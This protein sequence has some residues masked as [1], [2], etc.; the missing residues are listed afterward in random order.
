MVKIKVKPNAF[1]RLTELGPEV[2]GEINARLLNNETP[3]DISRWLHEDLDLMKDVKVQSVA[4]MIARYRVKALRKHVVEEALFNMKGR[5][6]S[7]LKTRL[8]ALDEI[9]ELVVLQRGRVDQCLMIEAGLQRLSPATREEMKLLKDLLVQLGH[10]QLEMGILPKASK[11]ITGMVVEDGKPKSFSWTEEQE[12]LSRLIEAH[13]S[14]F[15][16][17]TPA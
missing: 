8:S 4:K 11:T 5:S 6:T 3:A 17:A 10:L 9:E 15:E 1:S 16:D 13:V 2:M 12:K 14:E 7:Q